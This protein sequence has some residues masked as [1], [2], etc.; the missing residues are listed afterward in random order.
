MKILNR[1]STWL[2]KSEPESFRRWPPGELEEKKRYLE[3]KPPGDWTKE[4]NYLAVEWVYQRYLPEGSEPSP[5]RWRAVKTD[6]CEK[7]DRNYELIKSG[8][9]LPIIADEDLFDPE[10]QK[11][12][13]QI[14]SS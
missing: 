14:L 3:G 10:F 11:D 5:E 2:R 7:I 8:K 9:P 12:L 13:E 4:D 1:I 6:F